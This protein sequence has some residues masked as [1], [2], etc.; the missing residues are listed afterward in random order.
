MGVPGNSLQVG[1]PQTMTW[2]GLWYLTSILPGPGEAPDQATQCPA[3]GVVGVVS[4]VTVVRVV[5]RSV[6]KC[7]AAK[8]NNRGGGRA[9]GDNLARHRSH[10]LPSNVMT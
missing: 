1:R 7:G 6:V 8:A 4:R 3:R 9:A 5:V 10:A 2:S